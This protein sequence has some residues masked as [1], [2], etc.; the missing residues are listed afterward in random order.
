MSWAELSASELQAMRKILMLDVKEAAEL[1]ANVSVRTWQYWESG[2]SKT[3]DDVE[4]EIYGLIEQRN[5]M[6]ED[7]VDKLEELDGEVLKM[8]YFHTYE[9]Y[10]KK[11]PG[12]N[13]IDWRL[14]QSA[15]SFVFSQGGD[16][17]LI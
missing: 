1:I 2:R 4:M 5:R 14:H 13:K 17:E 16:V 8:H 9:E 7:L 12:K 11:Y 6:I 10:E 15:V 3:P